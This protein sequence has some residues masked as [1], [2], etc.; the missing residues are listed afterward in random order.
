M[1]VCVCG[2]CERVERGGGTTK[3]ASPDFPNVGNVY[4]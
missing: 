2:V 4:K 3:R 1:C